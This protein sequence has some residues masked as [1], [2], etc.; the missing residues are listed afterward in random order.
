MTTKDFHDYVRRILARDA[1]YIGEEGHDPSSTKGL[2]S[3]NRA[4]QT[5][6]FFRHWKKMSPEEQRAPLFDCTPMKG[7]SSRYC[8]AGHS[9]NVAGAAWSRRF[10]CHCP[11]CWDLK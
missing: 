6:R 5:R 10:S 4:T 7:S 11:P 2:S 3:A 1:P 8:V 9:S